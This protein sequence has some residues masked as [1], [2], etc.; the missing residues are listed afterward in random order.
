MKEKVG[1]IGEERDRRKQWSIEERWRRFQK[2]EKGQKLIGQ[3]RNEK[4]GDRV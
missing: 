3:E 4:L 1:K 2:R